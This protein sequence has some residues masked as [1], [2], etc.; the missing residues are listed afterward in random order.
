M[1]IFWRALSAVSFK[2]IAL[3]SACTP[4][5]GLLHNYNKC[6]PIWMTELF[7]YPGTKIMA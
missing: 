3:L 1:S 7:A 4:E 2:M 5:I 6:T